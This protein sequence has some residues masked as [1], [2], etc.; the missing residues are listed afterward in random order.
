MS[1][2]KIIY[3][4][5]VNDEGVEGKVKQTN[6]KIES[7]AQTGSGAFSEVWTGALRAIGG[8]LVELGQ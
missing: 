7:A 8:K 5:D 2:G 1:D 4:V 6:S 3:D